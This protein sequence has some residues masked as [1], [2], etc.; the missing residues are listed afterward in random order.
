MHELDIITLRSLCAAG[1]IHWTTHALGRIQERGIHPSDVKHC[2]MTGEIIEQYPDDYPYPSCLV[3][4][5]AVN[6]RYLHIVVGLC[7]NAI[8][9]ITAYYPS[10]EKWEY[11]LKTRREKT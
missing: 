7:D 5:I 1:A 11:D 2:I 8:F 3:L 6:N 10:S 4:G 9:F